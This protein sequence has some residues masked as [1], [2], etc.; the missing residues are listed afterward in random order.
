[1]ALSDAPVQILLMSTIP[2]KPV[3]GWTLVQVGE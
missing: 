3:E 2:P 1:L